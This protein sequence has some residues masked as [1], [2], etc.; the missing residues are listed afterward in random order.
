[1]GGTHIGYSLLQ[2]KYRT[3]TQGHSHLLSYEV[4]TDGFGRK[5]QGLSVGCFLETD[6]FEDYAGEEANGMW[7]R[8]VVVKH[9]TKDGYDPEFISIE[10]LEKMYG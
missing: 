4:N 6:Q 3:C 7:W 9:I 2:K 8:G 1:M 10:R 5:L